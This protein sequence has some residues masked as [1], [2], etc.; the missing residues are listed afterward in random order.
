V[1]QR[2]RVDVNCDGVGDF[3]VDVISTLVEGSV[4]GKSSVKGS[5]RMMIL[6]ALYRAMKICT[7]I[8]EVETEK[9][10]LILICGVCFPILYPS[11]MSLEWSI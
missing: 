5:A 2:F 6:L 11:M 3:S 4:G 7:N 8:G 10:L 1:A 9:A